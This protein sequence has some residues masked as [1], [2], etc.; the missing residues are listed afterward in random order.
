MKARTCTRSFR[1]GLVALGLLLGLALLA[2]PGIAQA[3]TLGQAG[4]GLAEQTGEPTPFGHA[5]KAQYGVRFCPT[6]T[7]EQRVPSWDGVPLDADVTL[8]ATGNGPWP[9]IV[10]LH[11]WGTNKEEFEKNGPHGQADS[12]ATLFAQQGYA[13]L[14]YSARGWAGSCGYPSSRTAACANGFVHISDTRYEARDT[15][16]LLG[17]LADEGLVQPKDIG[18]MGASYGGGQSLELAY[19][20]NRIRLPDGSFVPWKSPAGKPMAIGAAFPIAPYSDLVAAQEPNGRFLDGEVAPGGQ[21][22]E[23]VGVPLE[24]VD[25]ALWYEGPILGA[26]YAKTG[27]DPEA[28]PNSWYYL[29]AG[30]EPWGPGFEWV[31]NQIYDYHDA[32]GISSSGTPAPLLIESGWTDDVFPVEQALRVYNQVRAAGGDVALMFGD[33]GHAIA[34]NKANTAQAF[35]LEA[36]RFFAANLK[37]EGEAPKNGSVTAYTQTCPKTAP[38]GGPFTAKEWSKLATGALTFGSSE[39]KTFTQAG[40]SKTLAEEFD[41]IK[42]V[43]SEGSPPPPGGGNG[44]DCKEAKP[45]KE[46]EDNTATYTMTSPGFTMMGL[47]TVTANVATTGNYGQIDARLWDLLPGGEQR[48]ISRGVYRLTENQTG[49]ITFQLHGNG[50]EFAQGDTVKLELLGRDA[51][52]YRATNPQF[53]FTV[54]VSNLSAVLPTL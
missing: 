11:G 23:P 35:A 32:A 27:Q 54:K 10:M 45:E 8:P 39:T 42:E 46:A 17:L 26:Y 34:S 33:V 40:A 31:A 4:I 2:L 53:P 25:G 44:N 50:Y 5:C 22:F 38:G 49:A 3:K 18:V 20:K 12:T 21:S 15:Q 43:R 13:V 6:E 30:G 7:L 1:G 41:P 14:T 37:Y 48:L 24:S 52:Y 36:A 29:Q 16:Y 47:P 51:P 19:L 9:T 28:D